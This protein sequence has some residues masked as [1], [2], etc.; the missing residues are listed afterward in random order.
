MIVANPRQGTGRPSVRKHRLAGIA[1]IANQLIN[2][3][4]RPRPVPQF[5][6]AVTKRRDPQSLGELKRD[7]ARGGEPVA[8]CRDECGWRFRNAVASP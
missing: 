1:Q 4:G 3:C 8:A 5:G 6:A 2:R 7:L